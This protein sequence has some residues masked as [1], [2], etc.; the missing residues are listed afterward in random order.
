MKFE[1]QALHGLAF[2]FGNLKQQ[3]IPLSDGFPFVHSRNCHTAGP[4][5]PPEIARH[6][7]RMPETA[8]FRNESPSPDN[9]MTAMLSRSAGVRARRRNPEAFFARD[10][11][12][13]K[14]Q[15]TAM[16]RDDDGLQHRLLLQNELP[17]R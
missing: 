4:E 10:L 5:L 7:L 12:T 13:P 15:S 9:P 1:L 16:T 2:D 3:K 6:R 11:T 8:T 17:N 14:N